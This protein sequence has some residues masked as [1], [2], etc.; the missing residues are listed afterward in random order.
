[1]PA[2]LDFALVRAR[3]DYEAAKGEL[4]RAIKNNAEPK[5]IARFAAKVEKAAKACG[6]QTRRRRRSSENE[7]RAFSFDQVGGE[8]RNIA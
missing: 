4:D 6:S 2:A 8:I 3:R 5:I 1:V 7:P